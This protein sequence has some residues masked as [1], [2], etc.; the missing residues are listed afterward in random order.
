MYDPNQVLTFFSKGVI[1]VLGSITQI[2]AVLNAITN[3]VIGDVEQQLNIEKGYERSEKAKPLSQAIKA[4]PLL[5]E[6]HY[7]LS[8]TSE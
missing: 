8:A 7:W 6:L 4:T 3:E 1:P 2:Y 5:R